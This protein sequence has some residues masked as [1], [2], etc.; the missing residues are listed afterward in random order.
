MIVYNPHDG[1]QLL[2]P[3]GGQPKRCFLMTRL[4]NP[5]PFMVNEIRKAVTDCCKPFGYNVIDAQSIVTGRDFLLKIWRQIA[6]TPLSVGVVHEDI[7]PETQAN[8]FYEIGVAQGLGKETVIV[9]SPNVKIASDF[10]RTEY[11]TYND[12]FAANFAKFMDQILVQSMFYAELA[13]QLERNPVLSLDYL[14]P[15]SIE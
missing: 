2:L 7:P 11:I 1:T 5:V 4:G 13:V 3:G 6:V 8:I 9:K 10:V 12:E 15:V 14:I